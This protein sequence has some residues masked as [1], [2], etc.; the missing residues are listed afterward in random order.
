[1]LIAARREVG[2]FSSGD[3]EFLHGLSGHVALAAHQ[4]QLY[5]ALEHAYEDLRQTQQTVM[6]QERLRALGQ[7]ASGIAHDINNAI[8]PV[9]LYTE[10]L[11]EKEPGLSDR[12]RGYLEIIQRAIGDVAETVGRMREFYRQREPQVLVPV[13]LNLLIQQV[14]DLTRV[15]WNDMP[16][17]RGTVINLKSELESDLPSVLGIESEIRDALVNLVFNAI[18]AMP[19]GGALA[20][21]TKTDNMAERSDGATGTTVHVEVS[22]TGMGMDESTRR[23]CLEPFFTTKG[24]RGTGLGLAMVYGIVERHGGEIDITSAPGAG[25]TIRLSLPVA[26]AASVAVPPVGPHGPASRLRLLV[27]DDDPLVLKSLQDALEGEGH[28]VV[29]ANHGQAGIDAF[30]AAQERGE[31]F[32]VVI[33]DLGMPQVDG[34]R[35]ASAVKAASPLTPV[36]LL[37]GW[38]QRLVAEGDIPEHVDRVLSKPPKM[39]D[40]RQALA[41]FCGS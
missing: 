9:A 41:D 18:D 8:S 25:T 21:R 17:E 35:V 1:V 14:V 28:S 27:V 19:D 38:G 12:A 39:R 31:A 2:S 26:T 36:L 30:L 16:Q 32:Q 29:A 37:T 11:L 15:R 7:M 3:C 33:T 34:R 10:S 22:D 13:Q 4:A 6:Q 23:R 5:G 24:D 20:L 40:L